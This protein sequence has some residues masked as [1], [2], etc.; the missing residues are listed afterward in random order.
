MNRLEYEMYQW[1][2]RVTH[3]LVDH[4]HE[5]FQNAIELERGGFEKLELMRRMGA[6]WSHIYYE[7]WYSERWAMILYAT[8]M[9]LNYLM[10]DVVK[11]LEK[12]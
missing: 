8:K 9:S 7:S 12:E 6:I 5:K 1:K 4:G 3:W 2:R 11:I 10:R